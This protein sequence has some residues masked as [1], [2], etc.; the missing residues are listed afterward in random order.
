MCK[1]LG[2]QQWDVGPFSPNG[3]ID[4]YCMVQIDDCHTAI[5]GGFEVSETGD[6]EETDK[7]TKILKKV[8][9]HKDG[10]INWSPFY[11]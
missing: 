2:A 8:D 5:I 6:E 10:C 9:K 4:D 7:V 11:L 3:A 1:Y